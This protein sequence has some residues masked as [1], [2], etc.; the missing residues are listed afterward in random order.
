MFNSTPMFTMHA[1]PSF[2]ATPHTG[3]PQT[4]T[5]AEQRLCA[6][7]LVLAVLATAGAL[8]GDA[9]AQMLHLQLNAH[10]HTHI[11]AHGHPFVDARAFLGIPNACDVLSNLPFFVFG[12]WGFRALY[13]APTVHRATRQAA[14]VFFVGLLLTCCSSSFYHWAPDAW[15]LAVDRAG[16]A[17]A[18]AGVLGLA[19]AERVSLRAAPW[20]WGSVLATGLLA[21]V[22]NLYAGAIAP[23]AVVQFGGMA[24]VL[25]MAAQR[26]LPGALGVRWSVL[27]AWYVLAKLLELGDATVYEATGHWVSGHSLKHIAASLAAWPVIEA[28]RHNARHGATVASK[29]A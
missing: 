2:Y 12:M 13:C 10:G 27:I 28:L 6:I 11:Y 1:K 14:T 7:G 15:G 17:V 21:I 5:T 18:F 3:H 29:R 20:V 25:W 9:L 19:C 24:V 8:L 22:L 26:P 23:W 4:M 16:M